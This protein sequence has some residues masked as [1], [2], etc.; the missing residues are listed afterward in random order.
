MILKN[1]VSR[2]LRSETLLF[3]SKLQIHI[4]TFQCIPARNFFLLEHFFE[5]L[6]TCTLRKQITIRM[7]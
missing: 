2:G 5:C 4:L 1:S 6:K 3:F 7:Q